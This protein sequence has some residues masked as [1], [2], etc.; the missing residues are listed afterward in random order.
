MRVQLSLSVR[1][2]S[3]VIGRLVILLLPLCGCALVAH[4]RPTPAGK[5]EV[6]AGIGGPFAERKEAVFPLPLV[7]AGARYGLGA[8]FD[9]HGHVHLGPIIDGGVGADLGSTVLVLDQ[10]GFRPAV[11]TTARGF[12]FTDFDRAFRPFGEVAVHASWAH[13]ERWLSYATGSAVFDLAGRRDGLW[14]VGAGEALRLGSLA[15][16]LELRAYQPSFVNETVIIQF[17]QLFGYAP[18]GVLFGAQYVF[19]GGGDL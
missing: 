12:L 9:V 2:V 11:S 6:E 10:S 13:G 3:S 17:P 19:G 7:S 8:R 14:S 1:I 18:F 16:N 4:P 5:I 15:L